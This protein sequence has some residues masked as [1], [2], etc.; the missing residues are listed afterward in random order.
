MGLVAAFLSFLPPLFGAD[1]GPSAP[2]WRW[3]SGIAVAY[4]VPSSLHATR[5]LG[6]S[7]DIWSRWVAVVA[8]VVGLVLFAWNV[9]SPDQHSPNRYIGGLLCLL[10]V[11]GSNFV[12][13]VYTR[14]DRGAV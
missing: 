13:A 12:V 14:A 5:K 3:L 8:T 7:V 4:W 1:S 9:I 6:R 2:A 10:A 11:A